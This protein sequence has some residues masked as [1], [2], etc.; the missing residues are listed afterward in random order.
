MEFEIEYTAAQE[1]F[2]AEVSAWLA[3]NVPDE[4]IG[5]D[6]HRES[7]AVYAGRRELGRALGE[8]GWLYPMSP[9]R[10]GGGGLDLD[11]ALVIVEELAR[12]GLGLPPYYDSGGVLGS[13]AILA[14][15][16]DEQKDRLLPPI[17][18]GAQRTW[19]LLTEPSA[20]SDL[21]AVA[22]TATKD[23]DEYVLSGQ[24]VFIGSGNGADALWTIARSGPAQDRHRNLSWFMIDARSPGVTVVPQ[25][26][27]GGM[28]KNT[29]FFDGVRVPAGN[30]V[31][32]ENKGWEVA[33][34]HLDHEHG[35][36]SDRMLGRRLGEVWDGTLEA[37]RKLSDSDGRPGPDGLALDEQALDVLAEIYIRKEIVRLLGLRNYWLTM[38]GRPRTYEGSQGYYLEKKSSQWMARALLDVFGQLALIDLAGGLGSQVVDQQA[39]GVLSMHGGGT[40]EIQKLLIARHL[41]L[42]GSRKQAAQAD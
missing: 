35:L 24:K 41:G 9:V 8:R 22:M 18:T 30:L 21:A 7:A 26:I 34:T 1:S 3:R 29:I 6:E 17:Y 32:G 11:S 12:L 25:H 19:Q 13:A 5:V 28:D 31:G 14:W 37:V 27:V 20:G 38:G 39:H 33:N 40:G 42:G 16:T 23:G 2:R 4:I 36:R 10:Y 15:G